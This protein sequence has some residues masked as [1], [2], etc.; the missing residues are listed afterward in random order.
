MKAL[1]CTLVA[2]LAMVWSPAAAV[3]LDI[4][5]DEVVSVGNPLVTTL[6]VHGYRFTGSFRTIDAPGGTLPSNGSAVYLHQEA[7]GPGITVTRADGGPFILYAFD[8]VGQV[9]LVGLRVGGG[10]L[11]ATYGVSSLPGFAHFS[12]PPAWNLPA[13]TFTGLLRGEFGLDDVGVGEGATSVAEPATLVLAAITALGGCVVALTR[14]RR[15]A[16][17]HR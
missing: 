3:A 16:F 7:S 5:F 8:A 14:Q 12:V 4:T 11:S 17:R 15:G 1:A 2:I 9:N 10:L 6:D 13:A